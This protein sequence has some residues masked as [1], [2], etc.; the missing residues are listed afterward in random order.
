[1]IWPRLP[2]KNVQGSS[3]IQSFI[4]EEWSLDVNYVLSV[5]ITVIKAIFVGCYIVI[6]NMVASFVA[7]F[8]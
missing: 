3:I 7:L 6:I 8:L 2:L 1:M 5:A 4:Y